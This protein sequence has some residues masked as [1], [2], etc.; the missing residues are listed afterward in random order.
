MA[1]S[2]QKPSV[3]IIIPVR[4]EARYIEDLLEQ[5][6]A[7]DYKGPIEVLIADGESDDGTKELISGWAANRKSEEGGADLHLTVVD[8]PSRYVSHGLNAVLRVACG[9]YI[10]RWDAHT[11]YAT[12]YVSKC[13]EWKERTEAKN[14]GGPARTKYKGYISQAVCAAYHSPFSVGG[15]RFHDVGYEGEVDTVVY[16]CWDRDYLVSIGGFDEELVRNQDDE[17]NLRIT[18]R[19]DMVYQ[20]PE[21]VSWYY[22][23][24][25]LTALFKQYFQYGYW[26][27]RVIQKH[28]LPASPRHLVPIVFILGLVVGAGLSFLHPFLFLLYS[29]SI[30]VYILGSILFSLM[31]VREYSISILPVL[32]LVFFIYH[33][34]YGVGFFLG[35]VDFYILRKGGS[36]A[37]ST[38]TS[39]LSR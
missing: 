2:S 25:S 1:D 5:A 15:A 32:P 8:N 17:L 31:A 18:R 23:R 29:I 27:V 12:D 37:S 7:Q 3:S 38:I 10:V 35:I 11:V 19:G 21:I 9:K 22:P 14:V 28:T 26:K 4:N 30:G 6:A 16:G 39:G 34:S 13:I 33:V 24:S 36:T 20:S